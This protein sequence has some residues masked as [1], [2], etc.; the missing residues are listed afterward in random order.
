MR[1]AKPIIVDIMQRMKP[2]LVLD[3]GCGKCKFSRKFLNNGVSVVGVD[4]KVTTGSSKNFKFVLQ[5]VLDFQFES[6]YDLIMGTG[7]LHYLYEKNAFGLINKMKKNT[8]AGGYHFLICMSNREESNNSYFYPDKEML[9]K[10]YFGW[11]IIYNV[12]CL[13]K[14]HGEP[15]HQHKM[16]VFLAKKTQDG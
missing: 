4:E 11:D 5:N 2:S 3:L 7:I 14:K 9:N 8:L 10:L 13:S 1:P 12:E 6:K 15:M 16:I